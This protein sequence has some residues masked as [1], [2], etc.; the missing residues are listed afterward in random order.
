VRLKYCGTKIWCAGTCEVPDVKA[1][2][3]V[4]HTEVP[5]ATASA[6]VVPK[7]YPGWGYL[8]WVGADP[9]Y[10]RKGLGR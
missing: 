10:Q 6:R 3:V 9:D 2:Y 8:H 1:I 5:V 7:E 4:T